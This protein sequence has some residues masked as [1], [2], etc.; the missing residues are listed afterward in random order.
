MSSPGF[1]GAASLYRSRRHYSTA[2]SPHSLVEGQFV[3]PAL[4]AAPCGL[5]KL[6]HE[7]RCPPGTVCC[8]PHRLLGVGPI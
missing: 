8:N 6:G 7:I 3:L 5:S 2:G 4:C 1:T